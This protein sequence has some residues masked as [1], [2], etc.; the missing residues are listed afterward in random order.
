MEKERE[1][2][3]KMKTL[4]RRIMGNAGPSSQI[5]ICTNECR[6]VLNITTVRPQGPWHGRNPLRGTLQ[7]TRD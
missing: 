1:R 7:S 4:R 6:A 2:E 3:E 5:N